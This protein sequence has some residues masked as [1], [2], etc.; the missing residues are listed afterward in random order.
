MIVS[1]ISARKSM[2]SHMASEPPQIYL[3]LSAH[4]KVWVFSIPVYSVVGIMNGV[5]GPQRMD[6]EG[7]SVRKRWL[8]TQR[9]A[10]LENSSERNSE[11]QAVCPC[12]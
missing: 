9:G 7:T 6:C 1:S 12:A 4:F 2:L 5:V 8:I 10:P 11:S 3:H